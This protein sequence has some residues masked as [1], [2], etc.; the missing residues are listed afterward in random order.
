MA[1]A[2]T[3]AVFLVVSTF[4]ASIVEMVE[5]LTIV[6]AVGVTRQWRSTLIG[7]FV[8]LVGL[9]AVVAALGTGA[10]AS[11]SYRAR[12]RRHPHLVRR[13]V[14]DADTAVLPESGRSLTD[15]AFDQALSVHTRRP[16]SDGVGPHTDLLVDFP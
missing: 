5:A 3:G 8:A 13:V 9:A 16:I 11:P 15:D 10:D 1:A 12:I 6:L 2:T 7:V 4:L 14:A